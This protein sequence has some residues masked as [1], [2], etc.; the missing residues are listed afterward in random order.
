MPDLLSDRAALVYQHY[1]QLYRLALLLAGDS[2]TAA[3]L[4]EQAF[5]ALPP[6]S[7]DVET[8]LVRG[9]LRAGVTRRPVSAPLDEDRLAYATLDRARATA[10]L[11]VFADLA[12]PVRLA[13]G[14]YYLRG[15]DSDEAAD[16]LGYAG[17]HKTSDQRPTTNDDRTPLDVS[18]AVFRVAA[19]RALSLVPDEVDDAQLSDLDRAADG[20][21]P[22]SEAIALRGAVFE[23][24]ALRAA[25]DGMLATRDL[26]RRAIPALFAAAPPAD[27]AERLLKQ[28]E[29]R[30][31][32]VLS[33]R[34]VFAR[35]GLALGV[36]A[37]AAAIIVLPSWLRQAP[38]TTAARVPSAAEMLDAAIHRFDRAP[39]DAGVLHERFVIDATGLGQYQIERWYDYGPTHRLRVALSLLGSDGQAGRPVLEI[40]NDG[41]GLV[42]YRY[43]RGST[44]DQQPIDAH[45]SQTDAQA[46]LEILR[47][48]PSSN[49]FTR[50]RPGP[51]DLAPLYLAQARAAGATF[52]GQTS[53]LQRPAY[54]LAYRAE[55]LPA[56]PG[57]PD[58]P[59]QPVRVVL[60]LDAQTSAL[61]DVAVAADGE[62]ESS[63]VRPLQ[64]NLFEVLPT[65]EEGL[66]RLP[67][68]TRVEQQAGLPSARTPEISSALAIGLDDV[69]RRTQQQVF[70][71]RQLPSED[72]RALAVPIRDNGSEQMVLLYEGEF[73][74]VMLRP[75]GRAASDLPGN[76]EEKSA[77]E[78]RYRMIDFNNQRSSA[79]AVA[80]RADAPDD[81]LL[82]MLV[83]AYATAGER[84]Q[85][86]AQIVGGL[87]PL[88]E[89]TL[90][91][92][93]R[94]FYDSSSAGGQG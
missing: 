64:A 67:T 29:R 8:D 72:M 82:V 18:L 4:V 36:L 84:E 53:A 88:T 28:G 2:K 48:E 17:G 65:V 38:M 22:E 66:W 44:F 79:A 5:R 73:Q 11:R 89:Q 68:T 86:L 74:S 1:E 16:V 75:L 69:L 21:L 30:Q 45:V 24:P 46:A 93:G 83:D 3:R 33:R 94:N 51:A 77:G 13:I 23:Q 55:R 49:S 57:Q 26:L 61:L 60:T 52:L 37:L 34:H 42:Q 32:A 58:P 20:R 35:V 14:L 54:L 56:L 81:A 91:E 25:R 76:G 90:P 63:V 7:A 27:L 78:F 62:G 9:L 80:Y 31:R 10:L 85:A 6:Q 92:L 15:L 70:A 47:G 43:Q 19:A 87:T 41:I 39:L 40:A 12:P 71:P 59:D 50:G